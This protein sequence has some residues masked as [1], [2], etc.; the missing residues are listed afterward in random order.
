MRNRRQWAGGLFQLGLEAR[1]SPARPKENGQA[2]IHISQIG[3]VKRTRVC[4]ASRLDAILGLLGGV[5][6]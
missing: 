6:G 5:Q 4:Q 3:N 1:G 2:E